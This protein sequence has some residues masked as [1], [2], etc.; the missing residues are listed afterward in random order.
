MAR[1]GTADGYFRAPP[2]RP[3]FFG[4]RGTDQGTM[5]DKT[6]KEGQT[7]ER[8]AFNIKCLSAI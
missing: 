6:T 8:V 4:M 2:K 7:D 5:A 1:G 3:P